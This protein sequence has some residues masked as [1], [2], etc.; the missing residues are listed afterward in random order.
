MEKVPLKYPLIEDLAHE[1]NGSSSIATRYVKLPYRVCCK[2]N[3]FALKYSIPPAI[4]V[5]SIDDSGAHMGG[6]W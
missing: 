5:F 2:T 1:P 4:L 6:T 3:P